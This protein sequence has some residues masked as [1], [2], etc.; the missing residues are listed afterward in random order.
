M[1]DGSNYSTAL[2]YC[3]NI[4]LLQLHTRTH[5]HTHTHARTQSLTPAPLGQHLLLTLDIDE[6]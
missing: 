3:C 6:I 2:V 1:C 5:T 4:T